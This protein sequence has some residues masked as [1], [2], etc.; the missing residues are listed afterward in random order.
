MI[1]ALAKGLGNEIMLWSAIF[2]CAAV[3]SFVYVLLFGRNLTEITPLQAVQLASAAATLAGRGGGFVGSLRERLGV[4]DLDVTT[5]EDGNAALRV[6]AYLS[7]N[8]YTDVE[9]NSQG[10][11]RIDLNLDITESLTARGSVKSDG[12]T[13]LGI[14]FERDY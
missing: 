8:L 4:D 13:S 7:D 9:V 5:D 10:E 1:R 11:T 3:A 12:E 2:L 6:G 14:F